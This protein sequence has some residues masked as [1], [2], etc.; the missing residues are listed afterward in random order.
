MA[1][2]KDIYKAQ[3][4][5]YCRRLGDDNSK[6]TWAATDVFELW[7]YDSGLDE[8]FVNAILEVLKVIRDRTTFE[9]TRYGRNYS[10]YIQVCQLLHRFRWIDWGISIR[11]AWLGDYRFGHRMRPILEEQEWFGPERV[12]G[13]LK[14]HTIDSVEFNKDNLSAF[15]EFMEEE[16]EGVT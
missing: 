3:Y 13:T 5:E 4:E 11:E 16:S 6:Y 9:Y 10:K 8:M 12:D 15:I 1:N 14:R 7:T 2:L